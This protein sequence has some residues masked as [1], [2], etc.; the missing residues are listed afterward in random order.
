MADDP[1][2]IVSSTVAIGIERRVWVEQ[3]GIQRR[4]GI[5]ARPLPNPTPTAIIGT[6]AR[7][8]KEEKV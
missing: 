1:T 4:A 7:T 5:L 3:R 2:G 8:A 6:K